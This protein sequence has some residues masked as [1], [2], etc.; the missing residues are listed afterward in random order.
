VDEFLAKLQPYAAAISAAASLAFLT[1]LVHFMRLFREA[2]EEQLKAVREQKGIAEERLKR[3]EDDL[4]R[5]TAWYER[6]IA[7]LRKRLADTLAATPASVGSLVAAGGRLDVPADVRETLATVVAAITKL[8]QAAPS[9]VPAEDPQL[10]LDLAKGT[11]ANEDWTHAAQHY[12]AYLALRPDEWEVHFLL[13]IALANSRGGD[14]TNLRALRALSE[15][16]AL[17]PQNL[18]PNLKARLYGYR[19]ADFKRLG[20]LEEAEHDLLFAR[21]LATAEY[22]SYDITYNLAGVYAMMRRRSDLL[23]ELRRLADRPDW[24]RVVAVRRIYFENFWNDPAFQ[25]IIAV[26]ER[27][28]A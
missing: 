17:A 5:N 28:G 3:A 6:E 24:L 25:S 16:I 1:F 18:E 21:G 7:D 13:A 15:A 14:T 8:Q 27:H 2:H 20:R 4:K 11:S 12:A 10:L 23:K 22:E 9:Q 19:G 26:S